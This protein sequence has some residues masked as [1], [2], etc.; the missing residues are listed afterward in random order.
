[1]A[2]V[3]T[4][5][6]GLY[7]LA[8]L[9]GV[10]LGYVIWRNREQTGAK[11]LFAVVVAAWWWSAALFLASNVDSFAASMWFLRS[12][13]LGIV[14][15][16]ASLFLFAVEYTGRQHLITPKTLALVSI[17]PVA[18]ALL[19][20]SNPA[21][22]F[23][24]SIRPAPG[25][26]TGVT[27]EFGPAFWAHA[28]Y[29]YVLLAV[30]L[31]VLF[32][33]LYRSGRLY[34][35]QFILLFVSIL[36]TAGANYAYVA[37][38]VSFDP[39]PIG[40]L[41]AAGLFTLALTRYQ[42]ITIIP[43]A[44]DAVLEEMNDAV[45]VVDT[46]DRLIDVNAAGRSILRRMADGELI[47]QEVESL[48]ASAPRGAEVYAE[49]TDADSETRREVELGETYLDVTA[50]P[51]AP[52]G[53][54]PVGW[55]F[56][57]RDV[58]Q[59]K[60]REEELRRR[61][62][63]LDR[64]ASVVS[65]DLRNPLGVAE[66]YVEVARDTG[67]TE[68]LEEVTEAHDRMKTI[69]DDVLALA[70]EGEVVT[71]PDPASL[72]DIV[73]EAWE[74]VDTGECDLHIEADK[75]ILADRKR[76]VRVFEN[77]FRNAADHAVPETGMQTETET[78]A[79]DRAGV[80]ITVGPTDGG[81]YVADDGVGLPADAGERVFESGYTTTDEGVGAGLDIV[82][83]IAEAH[84]WTVRAVESAAGGARFEFD[85]VERPDER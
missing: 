34:R 18:V 10:G 19:V 32:R 11:P 58:T 81:F 30:A 76:V 68:H 84:G 52:N 78:E 67:D 21:D 69:I 9:S 40:I 48:L 41:L 51:L 57:A 25:T 45:F 22:V 72:R 74:N 31:I 83:Q 53:D 43:V 2:I 16:V 56:L 75:S 70:R 20:V 4:L 15:I 29:S 64:F 24:S 1:M 60:R 44:R 85:G 50:T 55:L 39:A 65:H 47:G 82:E 66:G 33:T 23:F 13:Y 7:A 71:D 73:T 12:S 63:Q 27:I 46:D 77:L 42:L 61:N 5:V 62:E 80:T 35:W 38:P 14:V 28:L 3:S 79:E 54:G 17:H 37:G 6:S 36:V 8:A 49:L 59:R 26:V